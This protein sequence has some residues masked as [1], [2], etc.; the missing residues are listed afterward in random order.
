M[1]FSWQINCSTI[2]RFLELI[3]VQGHEVGSSK[4]IKRRKHPS[5]NAFALRQDILCTEES[6]LSVL[7][8]LLDMML[9]K[10]D[11][12]ER[13]VAMSPNFSMPVNQLFG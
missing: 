11:I 10:K 12:K 3:L 5:N 9:Q 7:M 13:S 4:R 8:A 2:V 6:R 1:L